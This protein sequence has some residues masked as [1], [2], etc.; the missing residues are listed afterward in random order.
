MAI[1][2]VTAVAVDS[3]GPDSSDRTPTISIIHIKR[4]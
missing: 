3:A 1:V 4:I 2:G